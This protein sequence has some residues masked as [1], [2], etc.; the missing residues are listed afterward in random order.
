V[1]YD[2]I[3]WLFVKTTSDWNRHTKWNKILIW[4]LRFRLLNLHV[5]V[6]LEYNID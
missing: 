3:N 4:N 2:I 6:C 5:L 1:N